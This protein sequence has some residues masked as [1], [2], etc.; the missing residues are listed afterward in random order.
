MSKTTKNN[1]SLRVWII[2]ISVSLLLVWIT[3][4]WSKK[5]LIDGKKQE[6]LSSIRQHGD[7]LNQAI[8]K[9]FALLNGLF[10][11]TSSTHSTPQIDKH[12][13]NFAAGLY[14]SNK[15]IRNFV[16]APNG[17]NRYVY[18]MKGNEV[19]PGHDQINDKR[20]NVR[21]DVQRS[22]KTRQITLSGPYKLRQGGL[23]LVARK[24]VYI[25]DKFW[26]FVSMVI[27]IPPVLEET[28]LNNLNGD[29]IFALRKANGSIFYGNE[30]VFE[31]NPVI[32]FID[33]PDGHWELAGIP[34]AGWDGI[35]QKSLL[36]Y[37]LLSFLII[38]LI[39]ALIYQIYSRQSYLKSEVVMRTSELKG[40]NEKL[41]VEMAERNKSVN[42]LE[43]AEK[44][45]KK[46][47][48]YL[49]KINETFV[50]RELK[51]IE[52]KK[53]IEELKKNQ[54]S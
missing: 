37:R 38:I 2:I 8:A 31:D 48:N 53:E 29:M 28:T 20:P 21:K 34:E 14:V 44:E 27:D 3:D 19:V 49:K 13:D 22:M 1:N 30:Q 51:M 12:F 35:I 23:G 32:V 16:I 45:L 9:R 11:F 15:G 50:G 54:K 43:K 7:S 4:K 39:V 24:A 17:I 33:L 47:M 10:A 41:K 42:E 46:N 26:G 18:P 52:L 25:E 6:Y 36:I 40:L 5:V